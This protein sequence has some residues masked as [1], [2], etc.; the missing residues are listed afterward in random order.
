MAGGYFSIIAYRLVESPWH[1]RQELSLLLSLQGWCHLLTAGQ[2][3]SRD[4][5]GLRLCFFQRL[6]PVLSVKPH[7]KIL[8]NAV[9]RGQG[10]YPYCLA[11]FIQ[12]EYCLSAADE[13]LSPAAWVLYLSSP[14]LYSA[15]TCHGKAGHFTPYTTVYIFIFFFADF[16]TQLSSG[17]INSAVP[18][19][20]FST[21][22]RLGT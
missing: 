16:L 5:T 6:F 19:T 21:T 17:Y 9:D 18:Q 10:A 11:G 12:Q 14:G 22:E 2:R 3:I 8:A 7:N 4:S 20:C 15:I 13:Y 1:E